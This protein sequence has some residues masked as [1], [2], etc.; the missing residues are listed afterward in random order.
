MIDQNNPLQPMGAPTADLQLNAYRQRYSQLVQGQSEQVLP[1]PEPVSNPFMPQSDL[2]DSQDKRRSQLEQW[3]APIDR[4]NLS[5]SPEAL[6]KKQANFDH[7]FMNDPVLKK[8]GA[9]IAET[10]Q[11]LLGSVQNG[12]MS[13][14][15]AHSTMIDYLDQVVE[16]TIDKHHNESSPGLLSEPVKKTPKLLKGGK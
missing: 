2:A 10:M 11:T 5:D 7:H 6:A 15:Q 13:M 4:P 12:E 3:L 1:K 16:P 9:E 8:H 14:A